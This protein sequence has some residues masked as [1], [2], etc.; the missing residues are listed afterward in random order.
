MHIRFSESDMQ[1]AVDNA[2][3]TTESMASSPEHLRLLTAVCPTFL[4]LATFYISDDETARA[5]RAQLDDKE[6]FYASLHIELQILSETLCHWDQRVA[7]PKSHLERA[8]EVLESRFVMRSKVRY[9]ITTTTSRNASAGISRASQH[10]AN[11]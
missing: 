2:R 8:L 11:F 7:V 3:P 9:V 6:P 4:R 10:H 5:A 1:V